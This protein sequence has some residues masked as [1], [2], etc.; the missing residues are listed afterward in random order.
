MGEEGVGFVI[1]PPVNFIGCTRAASDADWMCTRLLIIAFLGALANAGV[2]VS[3][4]C[5][6]FMTNGAL[7]SAG[8]R[9]ENL[10]TQQLGPV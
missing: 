8:L 3:A 2:V 9:H 4:R 5:S 6:S 7:G 10:W 1:A